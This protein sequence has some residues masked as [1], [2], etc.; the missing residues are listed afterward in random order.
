MRKPPPIFALLALSALFVLG[1]G[2]GGDPSPPDAGDTGEGGDSGPGDTEDADLVDTA[3]LPTEEPAGTHLR[4]DPTSEAY[5]DLPFPEDLRRRPDGTLGFADWPGMVDD[6]LL[7]LWVPAADELVEGWGVTS[8]VLC[9]FTGPLDP[10]SLPAAPLSAVWQPGTKAPS[11]FIIDVDP[12]SPERGRTFPMEFATRDETGRWTD[13]NRLMAVPHFGL[14]RRPLTRYAFVLTR[15]V[16]DASGAALATPRWLEWLMAGAPA[17][18][19]WGGEVDPGPYEETAD[20]LASLGLDPVDV[21]GLALFTTGDP[22]ARLRRVAEWGDA[23]PVPGLKDDALSYNEAYD[24]YV[25][26]KGRHSAPLYQAGE[27]PYLEGGGEIVF[28]PD[29]DPVIQE[30]QWVRFILSIPKGPMPAGGWPLVIYMH[31]SGGEWRQMLDRGASPVSEPGTGP[32]LTFAQHGV[33]GMSFDFPLHG[34]R[35]DPPD[36]SGLY[37][38]NLFGN[39][40]ATVDN[41][42]V[43]AVELSLRARFA[44]ELTI[45]PE[46]AGGQLDPGAAADGLVRFDPDA[47][48]AMGQSMGST[49]GVPWATIDRNVRALMLS[50]S[51]GVLVEIAATAI[52]PLPIKP[53]LEILIGYLSTGEQADRMDPVLHMLQHYWDLVDPVAHAR[54]V[55]AEPH[56]AIPAKHVYQSSGLE[57][58]YFSARARAALGLAMGLDV[59]TPA[60]EAE[61]PLWLG[62]GG[63]GAVA[64][65]VSGNAAG[66]AV[67]GVTVQFE[68]HVPKAG[69]YVS[70]ELAAPKAHYGCFFKSAAT[71]DLPAVIGIDEALAGCP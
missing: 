68:P 66:G 55:F 56:P 1:C 13:P 34:D 49:I 36:T 22:S 31:G 40:R 35:S 42:I 25:V 70:F 20:F 59:L 50:G 47:I 18:D 17:P 14:T 29:G 11:A 67:T 24:E 38:Y 60:L 41:F 10:A 9:H 27:R 63:L 15:D 19:R 4:F 39:P 51:G 45:D 37:L 44:A 43:S 26:L 30:E 21:A 54:H 71:G 16:R 69:H 28:G 5:F 64:P 8:G 48:F 52:E 62:W 53:N 2:D 61:L 58:G 12:A 65:G 57:D 33:A 23:Q 3:G 32:A 6:A 46:I 7:G